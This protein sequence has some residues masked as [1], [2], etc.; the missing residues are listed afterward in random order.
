V[1]AI[2]ALGHD[3]YIA[4]FDHL[5]VYACRILVPG[6]SEIYP[7]DDLEWEN[8]SVANNLREAVLYLPDLDD[9]ECADLLETLNESGLADERLVAAL[10]GLAPGDDTF[11]KDLRVGELKTL[12]ALAIGDEEA[13]A[14]GCEWVRHFEQINPDRRRVYR[15]V[16][17]LL[18][19]DDSDRYS[20]AL[21]SLYGAETLGQAKAL[22]DGE[23]RFFGQP[24]PGLDL[25]GCDMHQRLLA[26]Y[27]KLHGSGASR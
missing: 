5:G 10:I 17:C 23:L 24:A 4:D 26:A 11:W 20:G 2:H 27:G 19:L 1:D 22:L 25:A 6:M 13:L 8:N 3:I 7:V 12:L 14:E 18:K 16:E 21:E 9:D 15:C